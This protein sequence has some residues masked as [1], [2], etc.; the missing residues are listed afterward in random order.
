MTGRGAWR[1]S[2]LIVAGD[3]T[4]GIVIH[5]DR[6]RTSFTEN[7]FTM[8]SLRERG[9]SVVGILR[10]PDIPR[11]PY[12]FLRLPEKSPHMKSRDRSCVA[13]SQTG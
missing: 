3:K 4:R 8:E 9:P 7:A 13:C 5:K 10:L 12:R 1:Q 2:Y 6:D 11:L